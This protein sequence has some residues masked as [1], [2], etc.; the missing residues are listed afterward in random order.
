MNAVNPNNRTGYN[1]EKKPEKGTVTEQ[2]TSVVLLLCFWIIISLP[3]KIFTSQGLSSLLQ[4]LF[5]GLPL[6][7]LVTSLIRQPIFS[8]SEIKAHRLPNMLRLFCYVF[9]LIGQMIIAGVDV[10]RRVMRIKPDISPGFIKVN[11]TLFDDLSVTLN[12][13]SITLTPG[14]I[15]VDVEKKDDGCTFWVH[16]ISK[17]GLENI[18][19]RKGFVEKILNIYR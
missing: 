7:L 3:D 4:H 2:V 9:Y 12:A 17:E 15:T 11:T 10:A 14:T 16:S 8:R 1:S 5:V 19:C 6:A 18:R 13:N